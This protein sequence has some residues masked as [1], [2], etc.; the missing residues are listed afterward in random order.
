MI[1]LLILGALAAAQDP[2]VLINHLGAD[3]IQERER[4]E[5]DLRALGPAILPA[6]RRA[7]SGQ[8]AAE[9]RLRAARIIR[10]HTQVR[11]ALTLAGAAM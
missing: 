8:H 3:T 6:L 1:A 10:Y 4:A 5:A 7:T 11:W 9:I 2:A